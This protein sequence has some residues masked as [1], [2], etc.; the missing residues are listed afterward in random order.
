MVFFSS[1]SFDYVFAVYFSF[2]QCEDIVLR[3]AMDFAITIK[4]MSRFL[5]YGFISI[6]K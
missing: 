2:F 3:S 5:V 4:I 6:S 1:S